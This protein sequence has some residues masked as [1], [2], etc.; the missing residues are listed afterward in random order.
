MR[1][2]AKVRQGWPG[3]GSCTAWQRA[4]PPL[5][6]AASLAATTRPLE[7]FSSNQYLHAFVAEHRNCGHRRLTFI[8]D[9]AVHH[10]PEPSREGKHL[11]DQPDIR[12]VDACPASGAESWAM[13][14]TITLW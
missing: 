13:L 3:G 10:G 9:H 14:Q 11:S 4:W 6:L 2:A 5:G 12:A 7:A 1:R 8:G